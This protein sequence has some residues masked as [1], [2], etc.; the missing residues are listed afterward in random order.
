MPRIHLLFGHTRYTLSGPK[1]RLVVMKRLSI[2]IPAFNEQRTLE[3][4][5]QRVR[6]I[7]LPGIEKEIIVVESRSSDGTRETVQALEKSGAIQALYEDRPQ[8]KGHAVKT[9]LNAATGDWILIQDADLEYDIEDYPL[10]LKPLQEHKTRF[11]L[12]SR[13]LG[14]KDWKYRR[15]GAGKYFGPF[16]DVGVALYTLLFNLLYGVSLTDPATMFKVFE[17]DCLKGLTLTSNWFDLDW[18]L[19]AKLIRKG[20]IPLE[21]PVSYHARSVQEGKKIRFWRDSFMVLSAIIRFRWSA[22]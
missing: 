11:V 1:T 5:I 19:V 20:N 10:L 14:S 8:G 16:L 12:G 13:H 17:R 15:Q 7:D 6:S 18:E 3:T 22:L 2:V 21:I 9:G 4:L